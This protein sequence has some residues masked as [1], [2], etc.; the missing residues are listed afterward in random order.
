MAGECEAGEAVGVEAVDEPQRRFFPA[1]LC[2]S[3]G[4]CKISLNE[5]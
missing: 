1:T 4:S 2:D 5:M 3:C